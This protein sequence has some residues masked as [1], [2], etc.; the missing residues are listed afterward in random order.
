MVSWK[1]NN[2]S[3]KLDKTKDKKL[4]HVIS[5]VLEC[6]IIYY[7]YHY[8]YQQ[9]YFYYHYYNYYYCWKY[10]NL[11]FDLNDKI[12]NHKN[13]DKRIKK[14]NQE[15]KGRKTKLKFL[16]LLKTQKS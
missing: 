7:Y 5:F 15:I 12:K 10:K 11:E 4:D 8:Y 13:I 16:L 1:K 14:K 6:N 2:G 9:H 3:T